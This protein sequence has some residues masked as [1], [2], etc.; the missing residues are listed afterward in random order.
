MSIT[1]MKFGGTSVAN[2]NRIEKVAQIVKSKIVKDKHKVIVVVSAMSG[3]T[4][5]LVKNF[6]EISTDTNQPEYDVILSTGEQYSSGIM[7]IVLNKHRIKSFPLQ[8]WQI[9]IITDNNH[10]RARIRSIC[11][12]KIRKLFRFYDALVISGFQGL[13]EEERITTLGRGGSDTSA[14]AIA[15]A[16]KSNLCEIFTD[17]DGIFSSDPRIVKNAK[18]IKNITYEEI[19]EMSSAGSKVLHPRSVEL[20]MKYGIKIHVRSSFSKKN[21][22]MVIKEEKKLE[23]E[24]VT[25]ISSSDNE[26]NIS[27][28]GIPDKPGI[29]GE[30]FALLASTN[31]N[32]D[33]IVQNITDDGKYTS[34]TFTVPVEDCSRSVSALKKS[35]IKFKQIKFDK[36]ICKVSIVGVGM[37]SNVGVAKTMFE[38]LAKK[39]INI[40]VIS[41]SEIKISVLISSNEKKNALNALH[42]AY[43]LNK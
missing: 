27:L 41:T 3:V 25:G 22:T 17:V 19:L 39:N 30:I 12:K 29:A 31:I 35:K 5:N 13:S 32:V 26:A 9:P 21:G 40:Q 10:G 4:N 24:V 7:S 2:L 38:T 43:N 42:K 6:Y 15:A 37:K 18:K 1:I 28:K 33:M 20:A 16:V 23:K 14:V 34:L 8:G 36:D 11:S